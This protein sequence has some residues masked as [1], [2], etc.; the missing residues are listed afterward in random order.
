MT[1]KL[2]PKLQEFE[3]KLRRLKP[4][5]VSRQKRGWSAAQS[6]GSGAYR[7]AAYALAAATAAMVIV[8][9]TPQPQPLLVL[10]QIEPTVVAA[11]TVP[12]PLTTTSPTM[13]QQLAALLDEMNVAD[14]IAETK[15]VYSVV[16]IVVCNA[17]P[18]A[19]VLLPVER[20]RFRG[21]A[22]SPLMF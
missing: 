3:A 14:P 22:Y 6:P 18:K 8:W 20:V 7:I 12:K 19:T 5:D 15:P 17:P 9:L 16:E 1:D 11:V 2:D 13:R 21:D 4:L 10:P